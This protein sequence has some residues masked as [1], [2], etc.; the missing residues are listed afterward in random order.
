[1]T[2]TLTSPVSDRAGNNLTTGLSQN[3]VVISDS[4]PPSVTWTC[5]TTSA[6]TGYA[7]CSSGWYTA[8]D[9]WVKAHVADAGS[10]LAA[11]IN[12]SASTT[13]IDAANSDCDTAAA[14]A[15]ACDFIW[16]LNYDTT[17]VTYSLTSPVSDVAGNNQTTG[18]SQSVKR[19]ATNPSATV[20]ITSV[21]NGAG[22]FKTPVSFSVTCSD[23]TSA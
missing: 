12:T 5:S 1:M 3:V 23:A 6:T 18:L 20:N 8:A 21:P 4:T 13:D 7:A 16:H 2:Y 11:S 15:A 19:D 14:G 17:G 22:W 9:V 10:G